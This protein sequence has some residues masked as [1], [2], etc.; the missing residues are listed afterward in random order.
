M[1]TLD[2]L[3]VGTS[4]RIF[5]R[6]GNPNNRRI[7]IRAIV[8]DSVFVCR[9]WSRSHQTWFYSILHTY[10]L[11]LLI[12]TGRLRD[13]TRSKKGRACAGQGVGVCNL[14]PVD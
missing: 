8:D 5:Y 10:R 1:I 6:E 3:K 14:S 7:H 9:Q 13:I 4:V 12:E 2:D 11:E